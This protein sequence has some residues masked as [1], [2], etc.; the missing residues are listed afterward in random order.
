MPYMP[1]SPNVAGGGIEHCGPWVY[2]PYVSR[3]VNVDSNGCNIV[4]D[5][6]NE[7]SIAIDPTNPNNIVIGWRQFD[8]IASDF[9]Q[10]GWAYSHDGGETWTFPG[11][12]VPGVFESDPVL[13]ADLAGSFYYASVRVE[14]DYGSVLHVSHDQGESW[15]TVPAFGGDK[16]WLAVDNTD[17]PG[18]GHVYLSWSYFAGCC[19]NNVF[20]RSTNGG[21]S[22]VSPVAIPLSPRYGTNAVGVDGE[23]YV[24]GYGTNQSGTVVAR[25]T[26]A[27]QQNQ[28][29]SFDLAVTVIAA[30]SIPI[31]N[32]DPNPGGLLAQPVVDVDR[33]NSPTRGNV[34]LL[35]S[36]TSGV[37]G[38]PMDVAFARSTDHGATW[39]MPA[40]VNDGSQR[41]NSWQWFGALS[42]APNGRIDAVW[43]DTRGLLTARLSQLF[44]SYSIDTGH[45]WSVNIPVSP[46]FDSYVGWAMDQSKIGDYIHAIS[47]DEGVRVAYA[48]TYNG[49][50]DVYLVKITAGDC[51]GN[52][53][54]DSEDVSMGR[55]DD[56]ND[57]LVPDEC[58]LDCNLNGAPDSCDVLAGT[59]EDCDGDLHPDECEPDFDL[60]GLIDYCDPDID[61]DTQGNANDVCDLTPVGAAIRMNGSTIGDWNNDCDVDLTDYD[62]AWIVC[63]DGPLFQTSNICRMAFNA[64]AD[65]DVDLRDLANFQIAFTGYWP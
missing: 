41:P 45:T 30:N 3:Q 12:I 29:P 36:G 58:N 50:Q 46:V 40:R 22:F 43:Y 63:F 47:L 18:S 7:P 28:T 51:N 13:V 2:G 33:S 62:S 9:R 11:S 49:E 4:G 61:N 37:N 1:W 19:G 44:Y 54:P 64:D 17:G 27:K 53:Q 23:V 16:H 20:T 10:A 32:S 35:Q 52:G 8:T 65:A 6:A 38:D 5:A 25:S 59:S 42:V 39:S 14:P 57:D 31:P 60:D 21:S 34:Y 26:N 55:S 48:A 56:C 15:E 24:A